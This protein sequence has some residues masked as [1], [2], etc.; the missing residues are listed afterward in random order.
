MYPFLIFKYF[1]CRNQHEVNQLQ[2]I[3]F[4][5]KHLDEHKVKC[6]LDFRNLVL[7]YFN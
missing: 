7:V 3:L 1:L 5:I 2:E 4:F 6:Y